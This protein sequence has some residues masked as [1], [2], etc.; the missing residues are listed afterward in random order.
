M[1]ALHYLYEKLQEL[2]YFKMSSYPV[3]E[4]DTPLLQ[5]DQA[6]S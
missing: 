5:F 1:S 6:E 2:P 3:N 4:S